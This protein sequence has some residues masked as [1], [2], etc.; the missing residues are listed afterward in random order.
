MDPLKVNVP[1]V[2]N[3]Y[4]EHNSPF[5]QFK[6]KERK[7]R[8]PGFFTRTFK[9]KKAEQQKHDYNKLQDQ[10]EQYLKDKGIVR[11]YYSTLHKY[12][13]NSPTSHRED[14]YSTRRGRI[15]PVYYLKNNANTEYEKA[16]KALKT[17]EV[18]KA[19]NRLSTLH[20]NNIKKKS[21][22][23]RG[24]YTHQG[25]LNRRQP[26]YGNYPWFNPRGDM[27]GGS[28]AKKTQKK[29]LFKNTKLRTLSKS[30]G[31]THKY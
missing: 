29:K 1:H 3:T 7:Y 26:Y 28:R 22:N 19:L 27:N 13:M 25:N 31:K 17:E 18:E 12:E 5:R 9:K 2:K 4:A 8:Q 11:Q 14:L 6:Q 16:V 24:K 30:K 15:S 20:E 21:T 10:T 23:L